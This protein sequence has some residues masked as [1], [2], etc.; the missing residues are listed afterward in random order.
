MVTLPSTLTSVDQQHRYRSAEP[1]NGP[2]TV[3]MNAALAAS[4][5]QLPQQLRQTPPLGSRQGAVGRAQFTLDT[6]TKVFFADPQFTLAATYE[7]KLQSV[8]APVL[9]EG[10][11]P[12]P[13]VGSYRELKR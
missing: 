11:R 9:P 2:L 7:R 1:P 10:N 6:G 5:T 12:I 13:V 4:L 8:S 3:A